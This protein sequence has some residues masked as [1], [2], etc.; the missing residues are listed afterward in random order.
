MPGHDSQH[1]PFNDEASSNAQPCSSPVSAEINPRTSG[2]KQR[3][4]D[5]SLVRPRRTIT[6][7]KHRGLYFDL[8]GRDVII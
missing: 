5:K 1:S 6:R 3:H 2:S 8:R 7:S 4:D